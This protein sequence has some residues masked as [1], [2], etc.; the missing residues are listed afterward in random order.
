M[1]APKTENAQR[2]ELLA[3]ILR[4]RTRG[5][6]KHYKVEL[7]STERS[8]NGGD[9]ALQHVLLVPNDPEAGGELVVGSANRA[10]GTAELR[11]L[12]FTLGLA[13]RRFGKTPSIQTAEY[14][15]FIEAAS[16]VFEELGMNVSVLAAAP[17]TPPPALTAPAPRRA[18]AAAYWG[19]AVA[20]LS[21]LGVVAWAFFGS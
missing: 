6:F 3:M 4:S 16:E 12:G 10:D 21:A 15:A 20:S 18:V 1:T 17:S 9:R 2:A 13:E 7:T 11:T 8:T 19:V 5:I 14:L